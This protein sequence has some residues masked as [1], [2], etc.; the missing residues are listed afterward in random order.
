MFRPGPL[1]ASDAAALNRLAQQLAA[2]QN[3]GVSWPLS[4]TRA[5]GV[6]AITLDPSFVADIVASSVCVELDELGNVLAVKVNCQEAAECGPCEIETFT[7]SDLYTLLGASVYITDIEVIGTDPGCSLPTLPFRLDRVGDSSAAYWTNS[8]TIGW[9]IFSLSCTGSL[10]MLGHAGP[11][12]SCNWDS[13]LPGGSFEF[14]DMGD[15]TYRVIAVVTPYISPPSPCSH[16]YRIT[17]DTV[18]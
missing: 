1:S 14:Y 5:A 4:M 16:Y 2:V 10:N 13:S 15:G 6:P 12:T 7:C 11:C 17:I 8:V 9:A 18:P 3:L